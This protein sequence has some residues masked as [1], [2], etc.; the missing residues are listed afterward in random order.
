[1]ETW[2]TLHP[3][4]NLHAPSSISVHGS[5]HQANLEPGSSGQELRTLPT[6][7]LRPVDLL[8]LKACFWVNGILGV[9]QAS[10]PV[11]DDGLWWSDHNDSKNFERCEAPKKKSNQEKKRKKSRPTAHC[12]KN[13]KNYTKKLLIPVFF[14][15]SC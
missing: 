13:G 1:M 3:R 6:G 15:I 11:F 8:E 4:R 10:L 2:K 7:Q 14:P 12:E 9:G 5:F